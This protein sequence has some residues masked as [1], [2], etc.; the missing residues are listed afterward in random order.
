MIPKPTADF[1]PSKSKKKVN[2]EIHM[3]AIALMK[4]DFSQKIIVS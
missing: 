4:K 3:N 2:R 1:I